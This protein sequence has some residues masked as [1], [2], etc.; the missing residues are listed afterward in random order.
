MVKYFI[1]KKDK[2][3]AV[4]K[5]YPEDDWEKWAVLSVLISKPEI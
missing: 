4:Y 5:Y 3:K 2:N 1:E